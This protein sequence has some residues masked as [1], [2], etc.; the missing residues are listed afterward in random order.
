MPDVTEM[1]PGQVL[2]DAEIA[3]FIK[4]MGLGIAEAQRAL[5][6][7]TVN[8]IPFFVAPQPGLGG[9]SL[10][11]LGL[12]PAFYH[13]Q[14]A[15]ITVSLQMSLRI[16][17][18]FGFNLGVNFGL[19]DASTT[20][21]SSSDNQSESSSGTFSS[22]SKEARVEVISTTQGALVVGGKSFAL[23][24]DDPLKRITNLA[25]SIR[26][27][28]ASGVARALVT[29]NVSPVNPVCEPPSDQV[30]CSPNAVAFF[31]GAFTE[32]VIRITNTNGGQA[33]AFTIATGKTVNAGPKAD[34]QALADDVAAKFITLGYRA[35]VSGGDGGLL[36]AVHFDFDKA[37]IDQKENLRP[38]DPRSNRDKLANVVRILKQTGETVT[39]QGFTDR[40]GPT[41]YNLKL[42]QRRGQATLDELVKMGVPA[43]QLELL[44]STGEERWKATP[45]G[46]K[47][48]EFRVTDIKRKNTNDRLVTIT[49]DASHPVEPANISPDTRA[50]PTGP[51]NGFIA[52]GG[53]AANGNLSGG[54]RKIVIKGQDFPISGA[55]NGNFTTHS[56]EAYAANLA[57]DVNANPTVH[58]QA[59]ATG[60]VC[61]LA[62]NEDKF[63]ILLYSTEKRDISLSSEKDVKVTAQFAKSR[64]TLKAES[65]TGNRTVAVGATIGLRYSKQFD[66][67]IT[68]N[69]TISARLVAIPAPPEFLDEIKTFLAP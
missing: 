13:Y 63:D 19:N 2:A 35:V 59:W 39:I 44:A 30:V 23:T 41:D 52:A 25:D 42:G 27:D 54:G 56:P 7:N 12:S 46:T 66:Q 67:Q 49:G 22:E 5:D 40:S 32:A 20:S 68:G 1:T 11:E 37:D 58:V 28:G 57:R 21:N 3:E 50:A 55:A 26:T 8:Q 61:N 36:E 24:G 16:Q 48:P 10:L 9:K 45:D 53:Q 4:S 62:N 65:A 69:S 51:Q 60:N 17:K 14:H 29:P 18:D 31:N 38:Q 43:S 34:N 64:T 15:D 33:Q 6:E 47:N